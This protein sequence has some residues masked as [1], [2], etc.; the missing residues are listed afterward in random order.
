[1]LLRNKRRF[2][3]TKVTKIH[4]KGFIHYSTYIKNNAIFLDFLYLAQ[5]LFENNYYR[6]SKTFFTCKIAYIIT[7]KTTYFFILRVDYS[8][9]FNSLVL[10]TYEN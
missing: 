5:K 4:F 1:M 10:V 6:L 3:L 7:F 9:C 2:T 8:S